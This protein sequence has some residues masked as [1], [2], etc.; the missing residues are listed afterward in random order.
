VDV[1]AFNGE[2]AI[3]Q[4]NAGHDVHS[5]EPSPSK[6]DAIRGLIAPYNE[7]ECGGKIHFHSAAT[8]NVTTT[9]PFY[10]RN[11]GSE[12]D[13]FTKISFDGFETTVV[14][15]PVDKLDEVINDR[16]IL[17]M[18][19][20]TEGHDILSLQGASKAFKEGRVRYSMSEF[21]PRT[22]PGGKAQ[23]LKHLEL[24]Q[25]YNMYCFDC[26]RNELHKVSEHLGNS[27]EELARFKKI[28][29]DKKVP[30]LSFKDY[31]DVLWTPTL[32]LPRIWAGNQMGSGGDIS[33]MTRKAY[34]DL[35]HRLKKKGTDFMS[36][37]HDQK[38]VNSYEDGR[39]L[40]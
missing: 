28:F 7:N 4:N 34:V 6:A 31:I 15:V 2:D 24:M 21:I 30:S 13:S 33:C 38:D 35:I 27:K 36:Y 37:E 5:F 16:E 1:G 22:M 29:K 23:A 17:Y 25:Q 32:P 11:G 19:I 18:K 26:N 12:Q 14:D 9:M 3:E 10:I 20:D 39:E 40:D 8:S